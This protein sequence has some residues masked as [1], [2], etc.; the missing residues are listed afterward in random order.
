MEQILNSLS[1]KISNTEGSKSRNILVQ[2]EC[3]NHCTN[4]PSFRVLE[5]TRGPSFPGGPAGQV[6]VH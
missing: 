4:I 2:D 1:N 3:A 6:V 5:L